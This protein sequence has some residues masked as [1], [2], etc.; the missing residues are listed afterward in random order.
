M[1]NYLEINKNEGFNPILD[2][3][4]KIDIDLN[5]NRQAFEKVIVN[6]IDKGADYVIKAMPLNESIKD[7]LIDVKEAFK[8]KDFKTIVKTAV[9]SSIREGLEFLTIPKNVISDITKIKDI[10]LSGGLSKA[11]CAGIDI[12]T[13]KYFKNNIF[14]NFIGDFVKKTKDFLF[15]KSFKDK[16]DLGI[17][18]VMAKT[19]EIDGLCDSWYSAYEKFDIMSINKIAQKI[20]RKERLVFDHSS[21][22]KENNAIQNMTKLVNEKKEKLSPIQLQICNSL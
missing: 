1:E 17:E 22:T 3:D 10:A 8:T 16:V 20:N 6:V 13:K 2:I 11:L 19:K 5:K 9:N 14:A 18:K 15:S 21:F 12:V 7:I 4:K